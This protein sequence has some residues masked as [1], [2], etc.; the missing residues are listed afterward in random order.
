MCDLRL[1]SCEVFT[2]KTHFHSHNLLE[3]TW[4]IQLHSPL[5]L[6]GELGANEHNFLNQA[7]YILQNLLLFACKEKM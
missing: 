6:A 7:K 3:P 1:C 2:M 4:C 5:G